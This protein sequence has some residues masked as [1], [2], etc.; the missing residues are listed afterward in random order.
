MLFQST[1]SSLT[2]V[3]CTIFRFRITS[4]AHLSILQSWVELTFTLTVDPA[5]SEAPLMVR[6]VPP[7]IGPC[8]GFK[9]TSLGSCRVQIQIQ[10]DFCVCV[11]VLHPVGSQSRHTA[12]VTAR[13]HE[14]QKKPNNA[15][16]LFVSVFVLETHCLFLSN[17]RFIFSYIC[18]VWEVLEF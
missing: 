11:C 9:S 6:R 13:W 2:I 3:M 18:T 15:P 10:R 12:L 7:A 14:Q 1:I 16:S 8:L 17:D 5:S 4:H